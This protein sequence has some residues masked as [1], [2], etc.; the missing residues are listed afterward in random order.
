MRTR[1]GTPEVCPAGSGRGGGG[2]MGTI[3]SNHGH[4]VKQTN[5][6]ISDKEC[7]FHL[8]KTLLHSC[9]KWAGGFLSLCLVFLICKTRTMPAP[10]FWLVELITFISNC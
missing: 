8:V 10:P 9:V 6:G 5:I 3:N 4:I 2:E 7:G 1:E